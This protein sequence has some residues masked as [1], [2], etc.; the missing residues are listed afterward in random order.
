M[1]ALLRARAAAL[2][3]PPV[4]KFRVQI[5]RSQFR[6]AAGA[7]AISQSCSRAETDEIPAVVRHSYALIGMTSTNARAL[8]R[9]QY[10][11]ICFEHTNALHMEKTNF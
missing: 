2:I 5:H 8:Q 9:E 7:V 4:P 6:A 3:N 1:A 10:K 11:N